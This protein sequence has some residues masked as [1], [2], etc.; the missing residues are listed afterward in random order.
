M[1]SYTFKRAC[2]EEFQA[3][4]LFPDTAEGWRTFKQ[5]MIFTDFDLLK[6]DVTGTEDQLKN[7]W[8]LIQKSAPSIYR[9]GRMPMPAYEW[10]SPWKL[11][12]QFPNMPYCQLPPG[13]QFISHTDSVVGAMHLSFLFSSCFPQNAPINLYLSFTRRMVNLLSWP[14]GEPT[15]IKLTSNSYLKWD[16]FEEISKYRR[17]G[18]PGRE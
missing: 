1:V 9:V 16:T 13:I 4:P 18:I 6:I 5:V 11:E 3:F 8:S 17:I 14:F 7:T 15:S 2:S 12:G 10:R